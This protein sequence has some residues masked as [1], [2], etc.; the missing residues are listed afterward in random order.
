[1]MIGRCNRLGKPVIVATQ[2][3]ESMVS[4]PRPTRAETSDVANAVLD[5]ADCVML[6][7]ETAKGKY[8]EKT[9]E[10]MHKICCESEA[11]MFHRVV[12]DEL[13]LLTPKPTETLLTTAIAAVDAA[14]SQNA[15]AIMCLTT[16]G[17]TAFMLA[18]YRPRCPIIAITRDR[19]AARLC[20]LHRGIHPLF[21]QDLPTRKDWADDMEKR[22][23]YGADWGKS[24]GFIQKGSSIVVLSGWKPGPANTNTIRIFQVD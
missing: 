21:Y 2:M 7:G 13:R 1:M 24:M 8:P 12:F 19:S 9:V 10:M 6:S 22:F 16:T 23:L 15:A 11:A 14:F 3:L 20:H 17:R 18:R 4:K 5:G